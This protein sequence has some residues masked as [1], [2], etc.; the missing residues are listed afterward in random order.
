M[1]TE[2]LKT[3]ESKTTK[4]SRCDFNFLRTL[5]EKIN[6]S[7]R[8]HGSKN[9]ASL[10]QTLSKKFD[11]KTV[12]WIVK[13]Y[14]L[15]YDAEDVAKKV[16]PNGMD[17]IVKLLPDFFGAGEFFC[18]VSVGRRI[19]DAILLK[20]KEVIA[21]EVKSASDD[22]SRAVD[23]AEYY[24][25][26]ANRVYLVYDSTH[27]QKVIRL[28]EDQDSIGL[29]EYKERRLAIQR[30]AA[31]NFP[32]LTV[33]LSFASYKYL[34]NL[35]RNLKICGKGTKQEMSKRITNILSKNQIQQYFMEFLRDKAITPNMATKRL[36]GIEQICLLKQFL[37][38]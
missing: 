35:A 28:F 33:L 20:D 37:G 1:L 18:E 16:G 6:L 11:S 12:D 9:K 4:L 7:Y 17:D 10:V 26:W 19:C 24:S 13:M 15:C 36:L 23:Q 8:Y 27:A 31:L 21:I 29:L 14:L 22:V 3:M 32:D 25:L 30:K 38:D 34:R 2:N 5:A